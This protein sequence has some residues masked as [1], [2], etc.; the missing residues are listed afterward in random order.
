MAK[1]FFAGVFAVFFLIALATPLAA[2]TGSLTGRVSNA[3]N[4]QPIAGALV[5]IGGQT[6]VTDSSGNYTIL[7]ISTSSSL[8]ADFIADITT[9]AAPLTV[10]FTNLTTGLVATQALTAT[11]TGFQSFASPVSILPGVTTTFSFTMIPTSSV[12]GGALRIVLTWGQ[13]PSDLNSHLFTPTIGGAAHHVFFANRGSAA[14]APFATLDVDDVTG[15]GPETITIT[16]NNPGEY[17]YLVHHFS[18]SQ[19]I[20]TSN[21]RVDVFDQTGLIQSFTP[22]ANCAN[23][24]WHVFNFD[25]GTQVITPVQTQTDSENPPAP[26]TGCGGPSTGGGSGGTPAATYLWDFGDG[27]TSTNTNP[28]HIYGNPGSYTV[29]LT[30]NNANTETKVGYITVLPPATISINDISVSEGPPGTTIN[31]V[32]TVTLSAPSS[33]VVTVAFTTSDVTAIAPA[34]YTSLSGSLTFPAGTTSQTITVPVLG[35]DIFEPNETFDVTLSGAVNAALGDPQGVVTIVNDDI[36]RLLSIDDVEI[37]EGNV[38]TVDAVFTVSLS[39]ANSLPITV[40]YATADNTALASDNDYTPASGTLTFP[41]GSLLQNISVPIVG[42]LT[43]EPD[44]FFFVNLSGEAG[45]SLADSQGRATIQNDDAERFINV[46]DISVT[47]GDTGQTLVVFTVSVSPPGMGVVTVDFET[48]D[49]TATSQSG[50]YNSNMGTLTFTNNSAAFVTNIVNGDYNFESHEYFVL[51]LSNVTGATLQD[52]QGRCTILN[53]DTQ[54]FLS[55]GNASVV[56]GDTGTVAAVFTVSLAPASAI[57][58]SVGYL[59]SDGT[60]AVADLDYAPAS[61]TLTFAPG[62]TAKQ[63]TVTI[64]G[65]TNAEPDEVFFVSLLNPVNALLNVGQG[66]GTI[67]GDEGVQRLVPIITALSSTNASIGA[68]IE[69]EGANFSASLFGN[70]VHFGAVRATV[71]IATDTNLTVEV[72]AGATYAPI[73]VSVA[74]L[75]ASSKDPFVVTFL[76]NR[77]IDRTS[78]GER[79]DLSAGS[80]ARGVVIGDFDDDGKPDLASTDFAN[81]ALRIYRNAIAAN[82]A[83]ADVFSAPIVYPTRAGPSQL[84]AADLN[85]DGKLDL[86]VVNFNDSSISVF[87]N[88]SI[89]GNIS[90]AAAVTLPSPAN[91][92]DIA[93]GDFN[94]DGKPELVVSSLSDGRVT[95]YP[96]TSVLGLLSASSFSGSF[97]IVAGNQPASV[98]VG[99]IDGDGFVDIVAAN[100]FSGVGGNTISL[101]RNTAATGPVTSGSFA[102]GGTIATPGGPLAIEVADLDRDGKL[103]LLT[104]NGADTSVSAFRNLSSP[105]SFAFGPRQDFDSVLAPRLIGLGDIDG[106]GRPELAVADEANDTVVVYR[107]I[108]P[109]AGGGNLSFAA[110]VAYPTRDKPFDATIGDLDDDGKPELLVATLDGSISLFRNQVRVKP[111]LVWN[112]SPSLTY[113]QAVTAAHYDVTVSPF[114]PG[115]LL[116]TPPIGTVLGAGGNKTLSATFVPDNFVEFVTVTT[117]RATSVS[118]APLTIT[119]DTPTAAKIYGAPLPALTATFSGLVNGD[120][121]ADLDTPVRIAT[122]AGQFSDVGVYDITASGAA[123]PNYNITHGPNAKLTIIKATPLITWASPGQIPFNTPLNVTDHLNA[124]ANTPG[125]FIYSQPAG[126]ILPLGNNQILSVVFTPDDTLNFNAATAM[127]MLDVIKANPAISWANPPDIFFGTALTVIDHLNAT[128][129]VPGVF[130]YSPGPGQ[131]LNAGLA[132]V[133]TATFTPTDAASYNVATAMTT[134][135]VLK[136]DPVINWNSPADIVFGT[137]LNIID[138]L[139]P[140]PA[141]PGSFIFLPSAGTVLN[142]GSGRSLTARFTPTDFANYNT[143]TATTTINVLPADPTVTWADPASIAFGAIL[144]GVQLNATANA[145]GSFAYMPP[146]GTQLPVGDNQPLKVVFTPADA[147]NYNTVNGQAEIDVTPATPAIIWANP[148][149]IVHGT[150]LGGNQ[151]NASSLIPGTFDYGAL[152]GAVLSAGA[153]QLSAT[154]TPTDTVNY[155]P[156]NPAVTINVLP[157]NPQI[158]WL[159]PDDIVLGTPLSSLQLNASSPAGTPGTFVYAPPDGAT[160]MPGNGQLL[161]ATFTP[162]DNVNFNVVTK[163]VAINVLRVAPT[164]TWPNPDDIVSGSPL[165]AAQLNA[166]ASIL[167]GVFAYNPPAGTSLG[168]GAHTLSVLFT[169][170]DTATFSPVTATAT[171]N[172]I[173]RDPIL[174]WD[175]PAE[176]TFGARLTSVQ[177]NPTANVAGVFTF[178]PPIGTLLSAGDAK[179]LSVTFNP[180]DAANY[181]SATTSVTIDVKKAVS[182]IVWNNPAPITFGSALNASQLNASSSTPGTFVYDPPP[183][184]ILDADNGQPLNVVFTPTDSDNFTS[185]TRTVMIDVLKAD[186]AITWPAPADIPYNTPLSAAQLNAHTGVSGSFNYKLADNSPAADAILEVGSSQILRA[187]F[188]PDVPEN[189]N[190]ATAMTAINVVKANPAITW[191]MPQAITFGDPLNTTDHL[192]ATANLPGT[193]A[194]TPDTGTILNAGQARSLTAVFTPE[195]GARYNTVSR[196]QTIDVNRAEPEI[197]WP[198]PADIVF[199]TALGGAQLNAQAG[200]LGQFTY[201]RSPGFIFNAGPAQSISVVFVP[202]DTAN[203]I[204]G[205]AEVFINILKADP[206]LAWPNPADIALGTP[207]SGAQLNATANRPGTFSYTPAAGSVLNAGDNQLLSVL[208]TPSDEANFN[209][210]TATA[211]IDVSRISV[212]IDWPAPTPINFGTPL[213]AIQQNARAIGGIPGS[214]AYNP[215]PGSVL[216]AGAGQTLT[217]TFTPDDQINYAVTV[218]TVNIDVNKANAPIVWNAPAPITYGSPLSGIQLKATSVE[219]GTFVYNPPLGA[220]LAAGSAQLLQATFTPVDTANFNTT[221]ASVPINV[222]KANLIVRADNKVRRENKPNPPLTITYTGFVNGDTASSLTSQAFLVTTANANSPVG[223]YDIFASGAAHPSYNVIFFKGQL[224]VQADQPPT[225]QLLR[226][227]ANQAFPTL[228]SVVL[229]AAAADD[230]SVTR[231][232]FFNGANKLGEDSTAPYTATFADAPI[233]AFT[234]TAVAT[235]D[236]GKQ[237]T[238][239][240]VNITVTAAVTDLS[241]NVSGKIDLTIVGESGATYL[242]QVSENLKTWTT[243]ATLVSNGTSQPVLD[244]TI[245]AAVRQRFYRIVQQP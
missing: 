117:N 215:P 187:E 244:D 91:P 213:G 237:T 87:R 103:D 230:G 177:L 126:A 80:A 92:I 9:G 95:V 220:V 222:S 208:F 118:Q 84:L 45:A 115:A 27:T 57:P 160:L 182:Q 15:F 133:L 79:S 212:Q 188:T 105:G 35:D 175:P 59:S 74:G 113:G 62:E 56:E 24:Y 236:A 75:S 111:N 42:D 205:A 60:A 69:I 164:I 162:T 243:L 147:I 190:P 129:S 210:A 19:T 163:Q 130:T 227:L 116:F 140:A 97:D 151:L 39:Q 231:V 98:R 123:D 8:D 71:T 90:F 102:S 242:V 176:I 235:D 23:R 196:T 17:R 171:I 201:S 120:T 136:A 72:P 41:P 154:F 169:P 31:A 239:A 170:A 145:S 85:G 197:T 65:D 38:G 125:T 13:N 63:V 122:T 30:A 219:N 180:F 94:K 186:P 153:H 73:S 109:P 121:P 107:N 101:F 108:S 146:A 185:E 66:V 48:A 104:S 29:R 228:A 183:T 155:L 229:E 166:T 93:V 165:G 167:N 64:N 77:Q 194:F 224:T 28:T 195:D 3:I 179:T 5:N 43:F 152:A 156:A 54:K 34:D 21:A 61:G 199:G 49:G 50:D 148:A 16:Q 128:A 100:K 33:S 78:F 7:N 10:N 124:T 223:V 53:D 189:Y 168:I 214:F 172:V 76:S 70:I 209:L 233:G 20:S 89:F 37:Q 192:N 14:T 36:E 218:A 127:I 6:A 203:Y 25:G 132:Q 11:A 198:T 99:D 106:D 200:I 226:P 32:L 40:N 114:V 158:S 81:G 55:I 234:F 22:P 47:E 139:N 191:T 134:I 150:P 52:G 112:A 216:N 184:T 83:S 174:S 161:S 241:F 86:A 58:V 181:N 193:F 51:N 26:G 204:N 178:N 141:T 240:P 225:V 18:G 1:R 238:S 143:V 157:A 173:K 88:S 12:S 221:L 2:Q 142:A 202:A 131:R 144:G 149:N 245:A 119:P 211:F 4:G 217:A 44:E 110:G 96:N 67:V 138:H 135:N 159:P 232:E 207:L 46:N 137:P 68:Q 206:R 82:A